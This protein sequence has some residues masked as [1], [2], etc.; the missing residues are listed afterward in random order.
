[1]YVQSFSQGR[2]EGSEKC[3]RNELI[4][5]KMKILKFFSKIG[6]TL[7]LVLFMDEQSIRLAL[8]TGIKTEK[9]FYSHNLLPFLFNPFTHSRLV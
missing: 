3:W 7:F 1:V 9:L 6:F 8:M 2:R 4:E 5:E